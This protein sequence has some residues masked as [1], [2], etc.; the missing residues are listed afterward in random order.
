[1][2]RLLIGFPLGVCVCVWSERVIYTQNRTRAVASAWSV[3]GPHKISIDETDSCLE[4][5]CISTVGRLFSY[6]YILPDR[7]SP[8]APCADQPIHQMEWLHRFEM[9][10]RWLEI[11]WLVIASARVCIDRCILFFSNDC[12]QTRIWFG[13][14]LKCS[15]REIGPS[16][17]G[18]AR[19]CLPFF[20]IAYDVAANVFFFY[21]RRIHF[22]FDCFHSIF[23]WK[24][25][26]GHTITHH[27]LLQLWSIS[28]LE[29][30][31]RLLGS[32]FTIGRRALSNGQ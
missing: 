25:V 31:S 10:P 1:M 14:T 15:H 27:T 3:S 19:G 24:K 17:G 2:R 7:F 13:F 8:P 16:L 30:N 9:G 4:I 29:K 26:S 21:Q 11:G 20:F 5:I 18:D 12:T 23:V 32:F 22:W 28:F 6:I